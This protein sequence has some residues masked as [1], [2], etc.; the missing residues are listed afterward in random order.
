M[1]ERERV[2]VVVPTRAVAARA[3]ERVTAAGG[4]VT[5][6]RSVA[7]ARQLEGTFDRA[8]LSFDLPDGSGIVLGAE[9]LLDSRLHSVEFIHPDEEVLASEV[10]PR[11]LRSTAAAIEREE[12]Q[13]SVA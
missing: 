8:I 1:Q 6:I 9:L 12:H 4:E 2:L 11:G 7:E 13:R 5:V 3:A 10:R